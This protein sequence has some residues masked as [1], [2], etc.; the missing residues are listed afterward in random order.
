MIRWDVGWKNQFGTERLFNELLEQLRP[1]LEREEGGQRSKC[2]GLGRLGRT[3]RR[4]NTDHLS[5]LGSGEKGWKNEQSKFRTW[6]GSAKKCRRQANAPYARGGG[7]VVGEIVQMDPRPR[8]PSSAKLTLLN[9]Y[10]Q[11]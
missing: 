9:E 7:R 8:R 3:K 2:T 10:V 1:D 5:V 4:E 11:P 6:D